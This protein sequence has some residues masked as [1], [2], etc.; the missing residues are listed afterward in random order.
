MV[1]AKGSSSKGEGCGF[2]AIASKETPTMAIDIRERTIEVVQSPYETKKNVGIVRN[3]L[4]SFRLLEA[5][6]K[7]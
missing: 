7:G 6:E 2:E 1:R 5:V 3:K 4:T